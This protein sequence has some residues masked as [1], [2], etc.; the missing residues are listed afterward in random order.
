M[1]ARIPL[2]AH[3]VSGPFTSKQALDAGLSHDRLRG[4]DLHRPFHGVRSAVSPSSIVERCRAFQEWMP[5]HSFFCSVTAAVI[6]R[7][8]LPLRLEESRLLHVAV[9]WPRHPPEGRGVVG[10]RLQLAGDYMRIWDGLRISSP[11]LLWCE[12]GST[13][14]V[15]ALVAV[16]DFLIHWRLP[17]TTVAKLRD[18]MARH[19]G[20]RGKPA[21]RVALELVDDRAES[22]QESRL[23]VIIVQGGLSG[24]TVNL[25]I[26]TSGGF[27]YRADL[28][29]GKRKLILEYQSDYHR[30][31]EQYRKDMTR[32]SRLEADGWYVL[33]INADDLKNPTELLQRIR[34]VLAGRPVF[35]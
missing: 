10:H 11:E 28:A 30:Y 25:P 21:L 7:V 3:L 18:A 9:P 8:P 2:P 35:A 12:L 19:P 27:N 17:I 15:P 26:K 24:L 22:P 1:A 29:I 4:R 34:L 16:G 32:I 14:S 13:L 20:R 31:P 23:R 6:M 5:P 33:L